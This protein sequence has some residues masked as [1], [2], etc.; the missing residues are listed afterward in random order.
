[1]QEIKSYFKEVEPKAAWIFFVS[2]IVMVLFMYQGRHTFFREK[3]SR[4]I[5]DPNNLEW[6][7]YTYMHICTFILFFLIPAA[8]VLF[9]FKRPLSEFGFQIGDWRFGLKFV[10]LWIVVITPL[11]YLNSFMPDFQREYP[12][13]PLAGKNLGGFVLWGLIY[14][15]YYVGWEFLFRGFMQIGLRPTLGAFYSICVQTIP[16]TIIHFGKPQG[17]TMSAI[18]AGIVFGAVALRTRSIFWPLLA[19]FYTGMVNDVFCVINGGG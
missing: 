13:V 9:I 8:V 2:L 12:L 3:F 4:Y 5:A 11:V 14:L 18:I 15:I 6:F 16:S 19:H 7:A 17:E 1:M 10:G